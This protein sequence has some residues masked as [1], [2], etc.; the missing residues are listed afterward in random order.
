M[1]E[2]Y[3]YGTHNLMTPTAQQKENANYELQMQMK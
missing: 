2:R 3:V 1:P